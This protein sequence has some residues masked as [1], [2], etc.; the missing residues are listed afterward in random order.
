MGRA[1]F[2]THLQA[3]VDQTDVVAFGADGGDVGNGGDVGPSFVSGGTGEVLPGRRRGLVQV[4]QVSQMHAPRPDV[5]HLEHHVFHELALNVQVPFLDVGSGIVEV[6]GAGAATDIVVANV[7]EN[8]GRR[9][10]G[11]NT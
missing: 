11:E 8:N 6:G 5:S 10:L 1:L 4:P 9:A 3:V 7:R 2:K